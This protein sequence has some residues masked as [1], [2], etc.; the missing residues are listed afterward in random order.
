MIGRFDD[1][2]AGLP[3]W[4]R[5]HNL[6]KKRVA[7][8]GYDLDGTR[9]G[10]VLLPGGAK[11]RIE[12]DPLL[13]VLLDTAETKQGRL[14]AT[15]NSVLYDAELARDALHE[16]L[17]RVSQRLDRL[18]PGVD[19]YYFLKEFVRN[20]ALELIRRRRIRAAHDIHHL[21]EQG[22][23]DRAL[24]ADVR[25]P[26]ETLVIQEMEDELEAALSALSERQRRILTLCKAEDL[27]DKQAVEELRK[28]GVETTAMAVRQ[29]LSRTLRKLRTQ[30]GAEPDEDAA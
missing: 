6:S 27:T 9:R 7:Y 26:L 2:L 17:L 20:A 24:V 11:T 8:F 4:D 13:L 30:L 15:A 16:A 28:E 19:M 22:E 3:P 10:H 14:L 21:E 1:P 25:P 5:V 12:G 23:A 29:T 18:H